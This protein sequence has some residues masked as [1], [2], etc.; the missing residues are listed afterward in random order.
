MN[1]LTTL[2]DWMRR[3][4]WLAAVA[5]CVVVGCMQNTCS[6]CNG[7][8]P[9]GLLPA[10]TGTF[11]REYY[12]AQA[13][14]AEADDFVIYNQEWYLGGRDLGP[15]GAYHVGQIAKRLPEVPFPV[16]IQPSTDA[17]LDLA[18][19]D[20]IIMKLAECGIPQPDQRVVLGFPD[21]EGLYGEE[22]PFVHYRQFFNRNANRGGA[23]GGFGGIPGFYGVG[24]IGIG[25]GIPGGVR[26]AIDDRR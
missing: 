20:L 12:H 19:R 2:A 14:K 25:G 8:V 5:P 26:G 9:R 1:P 13:Q 24:N 11:T 7:R 15:Y 3:R 4:V 16:V 22:A 21:A 18:R 6:D 10:P 17:Q 23:G